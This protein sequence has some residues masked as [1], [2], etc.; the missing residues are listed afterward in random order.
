MSTIRVGN[1]ATVDASQSSSTENILAAK[2]KAWVNIQGNALIPNIRDAFN[3]SSYTDY[4]TG[5]YEVNFDTPLAN[6]NYAISGACSN[7]HSSA[8][9]SPQINNL[10]Y[11]TN[12]GFR[13]KCV[14][15]S[16]VPIDNFFVT[17]IVVGD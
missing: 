6:S 10:S 17:L 16:G 15:G 7:D 11:P 4:G 1:I 8:A 13:V 3:V 12:S 9:L 14:N 5:D 2:I